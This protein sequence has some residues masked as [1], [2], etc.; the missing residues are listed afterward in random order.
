[1]AL[2]PPFEISL[3]KFKMLTFQRTLLKN[4]DSGASTS[5][6]VNRSHVGLA[7]CQP[8]ARARESMTQDK[9][10]ERDKG[11]HLEFYRSSPL[12]KN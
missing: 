7:D 10:G 8:E 4:N 6:L 1:M 9:N 5:A 12:V 11:P 3:V 2:D